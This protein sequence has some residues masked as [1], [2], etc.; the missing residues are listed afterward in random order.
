MPGSTHSY[1]P[2]C[3]YIVIFTSVLII[4]NYCCTCVINIGVLSQFFF[5]VGPATNFT[6]SFASSSLGV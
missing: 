6:E 3:T 4:Y 5:T 1:V 2:V